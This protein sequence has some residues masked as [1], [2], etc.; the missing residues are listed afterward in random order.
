MRSPGLL[1]LSVEMLAKSRPMEVKKE[2]LGSYKE[3]VHKD[4][5]NL[6]IKMR[7]S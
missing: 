1:H 6:G 7:L 4:V 3:C 5:V 2:T